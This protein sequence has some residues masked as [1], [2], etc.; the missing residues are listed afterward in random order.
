MLQSDSGLVVADPSRVNS[1]TAINSVSVKNNR[2]SVN[3]TLRKR[4]TL[5]FSPQ[6]HL[7][8]KWARDR[9]P[10]STKKS[11]KW[12]ISHYH[13]LF[14]IVFPFHFS[15]IIIPIHIPSVTISDRVQ[16]WQFCHVRERPTNYKWFQCTS[17]AL[18]RFLS[19]YLLS[20]CVCL[21]ITLHSWPRFS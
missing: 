19:S 16:S 8:F 17:S 2:F 11:L 20:L 6:Y 7:N 14:T 18:D 4:E 13:S 12:T 9:F 10:F 5:L 1:M 21:C 15:D 3:S